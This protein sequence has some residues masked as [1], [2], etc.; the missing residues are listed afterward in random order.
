L[1]YLLV[2]AA[3]ESKVSMALRNLSWYLPPASPKG[4]SLAVGRYGAER[5]GRKGLCK[6]VRTSVSMRAEKKEKR[7]GVYKRRGV[8][9]SYQ[10][11]L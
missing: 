11:V 9:R 10:G 7:K 5:R 1:I 6:Y 8:D 3:T 2:F 4:S